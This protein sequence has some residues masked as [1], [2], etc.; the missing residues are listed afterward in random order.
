MAMTAGGSVV[1]WVLVEALVRP[2]TIEVVFVLAESGAGVSFVVDQ[3]AVGAFG[4]DAADEPFGV[5]V[6]PRSLRWG[7]DHLDALGGEHRVEGCGELR[8]AIMDQEAERGDPIIQVH[9]HVA[10]SSRLRWGGR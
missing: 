9:D 6:G 10:V 4:S 5:T 7:P 2:V 1:G 3:H 8:V